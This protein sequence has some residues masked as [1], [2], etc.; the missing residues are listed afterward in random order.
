MKIEIDN[1]NLEL[2]G[3][4][5]CGGEMVRVNNWFGKPLLE[6][7]CN[8]SRWW[9]RKQHAYLV[10]SAELTPSPRCTPSTPPRSS[11]PRPS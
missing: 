8:R 7:K 9:N 6:W 2:T 1:L 5:A 4:C 3:E 10:A 11:P